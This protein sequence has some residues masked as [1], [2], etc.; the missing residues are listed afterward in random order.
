[1]EPLGVVDVIEELAQVSFSLGT[2]LVVL[3]M[4][5]L[6]LERLEEALGFGVVGGMARRRPT[7]SRPDL[8]QTADL[9]G[10]G[11]LHAAVGVVNEPAPRLAA[12]NGHLQRRA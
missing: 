7:H 10:A 3:E 8:L 12:L 2:C 1:V 9:L 5:R 4:D 11:V 6:S